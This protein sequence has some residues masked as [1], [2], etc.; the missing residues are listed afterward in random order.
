[1]SSSGQIPPPKRRP[2]AIYLK[3]MKRNDGSLKSSG[4]AFIRQVVRLWRSN[5]GIKNYVNKLLH[6]IFFLGH[7]HEDSLPPTAFFESSEGED[8][9]N[10]LKRKFPELF[11]KYRNIP[12]QTPFSILL[13][14]AVKIC[15]HE[16]EEG[17]KRFLLDFLKQLALPKKG[18]NNYTNYYTLEA[19]VIA[20][21][22]NKSK[23]VKN[24]GAS[25]SC[26]GKT[27]KNIMINYSCLKVWH[28]YVSYAVLSFRDNQRNG[29]RFPDTVECRAFYRNQQSNCYEDRMPC[30]NC[31]DL[32]SLSNP[33]TVRKDFPYGNCAETECLSKL[34]L[35]DQDVC[36]NMSFGH[37]TKENVL[38]KLT[39]LR[40]M[41]K[42]DLEQEGF[43][44]HRS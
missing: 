25:L 8:V 5:L 19:T 17:I 23:G 24:Y 21:C 20:V 28:D 39:S 35:C 22:H 3:M 12:D 14:L 26:R 41:A 15:G 40:S 30:Q 29:I 6:S 38:E 42:N 4:T 34:L 36:N 31:G 2:T 7:I 16:K 32:F 13:D 10:D 9:I 11:D 1:M 33:A 44:E 37:Y 43:V 27:G 18:E